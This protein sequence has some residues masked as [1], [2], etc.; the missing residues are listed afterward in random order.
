MCT[1]VTRL[2]FG[3][4]LL[5]A[6]S[7]AV[8]IGDS[9]SDIAVSDSDLGKDAL[10]SRRES[11]AERKEDEIEPLIEHVNLEEQAQL[12]VEHED[13]EAPVLVESSVAEDP[14]EGEPLLPPAFIP[15]MPTL[16]YCCLYKGPC[17]FH[18]TQQFWARERMLNGTLFETPVPGK[19]LKH[20]E[21]IEV[22]VHKTPFA[23]GKCAG[24]INKDKRYCTDVPQADKTVEGCSGA[25]T[26]WFKRE[27][28]YTLLPD[29]KP[30]W[31][32]S[33]AKD[34]KYQAYVPC[35][36]SKA[37]HS[38]DVISH[39]LSYFSSDAWGNPVRTYVV[40]R[41][42][43][44]YLS[45]QDLQLAVEKHYDE[46]CP[47]PI[48][49]PSYKPNF[50][51]EGACAYNKSANMIHMSS[52]TGC[53]EGHRCACP[54]DGVLLKD[55]QESTLK[56][57]ERMA[58]GGTLTTALQTITV[59]GTL[60]AVAKWVA[61]FWALTNIFVATGVG[62][63]L[64]FGV[65]TAVKYLQ[66]SCTGTVGCYPMACVQLE[67]VG[68]RINLDE[69]DTDPRNPYWFMPPPM[70]KCT[71]NTWGKCHLSAC[72]TNEAMHQMVGERNATYGLFRKKDRSVVL[73]C[74]PTLAAD[75]THEQAVVFENSVTGLRQK[76]QML[77][78]RTAI[79]VKRL[80]RFCPYMTP[81]V[82]ANTAVCRDGSKCQIMNTSSTN[83]CL[84][85][86]GGGGI[87][88]CPARYPTMCYDNFCDGE[89]ENC[90]GAGRGGARSCPADDNTC[91]WILPTLEDDVAEC[92]NGESY[93]V[94]D[95]AG[96]WC[97]GQGGL[98]KCPWNRPHMCA[99]KSGCMGEHCCAVDCDDLG[100]DRVCAAI[101]DAA[102]TFDDVRPQ[103]GAIGSH[104]AT[105]TL[106]VAL[107][108][109]VFRPI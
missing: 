55:D 79:L 71:T 60:A 15:G 53:P 76:E 32:A 97:V 46:M 2:V 3:L 91:P 44:M 72:T 106:A 96:Q 47:F 64:V 17:S 62:T 94:A 57:I 92:N 13:L 100:G 80:Q 43:C 54:R 78:R 40:T 81:S 20:I 1:T 16:Y 89:V 85:P 33:R 73:N 36:A 102:A 105:S 65:N 4:A 99:S 18:D 86:L 8:R 6:L 63:I 66:Y 88:Q 104:L 75:M 108:L 93:N 67:N 27:E 83:C 70:Y 109:A 35:L 24:I 25:L 5:V 41:Q 59:V 10:R 38:S 101:E 37:S 26:K 30:G 90:R 98:K 84:G 52:S 14:P 28:W 11:A 69:D 9:V 50:N 22:C 56:I 45:P 103:A 48:K 12:V 107:A 19:K 95:F 23:L 68:C 39:E 82:Y 7:A 61:T 74:Q 49:S 51:P 31:F 42:E 21:N 58:H 34:R 77:Q 87:K 29:Y